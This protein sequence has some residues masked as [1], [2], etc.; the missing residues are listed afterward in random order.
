MGI[1]AATNRAGKRAWHNTVNELKNGK[2]W[3][4]EWGYWDGAALLRN[5]GVLPAPLTR[6][7]SPGV[8][9]KS[10]RRPSRCRRRSFCWSPAGRWRRTSSSRCRL[11]LQEDAAQIPDDNPITA[12]KVALGKKFF[13]DKRWSASGTV[14]CAGCHRP[15]H[16]WSDSRTFSVDFAGQPTPRHAPTIVNR[17]FSDRQ[18][19]SG[20]RAS[21]EDAGRARRQQDGRE[22]RWRTWEPIPAYRQ[23][24]RAVF[25]RELRSRRRGPGHRRRT[26]G[27]SCP[28]SFAL[29]PLPWPATGA[30]CR[31]SAQRGLRLFEGKAMCARVPRRLQLHRRGLPQHR[32]RHGQAEPRPR[33]LHEVTGDDRRPGRVQDADAPRRGPAR[34][35]H[36][37]R[38]RADARRRGRA[39]TIGAA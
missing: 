26:C 17:L 8:D 9:G 33:P 27:R 36:A 25:G 16:G 37:R 30:R 21:L 18:H 7:F 34:S 5:I 12:E 32:R 20:L 19:W 14:S 3:V 2:I 28:A 35:V 10:T 29:R 24:F 39:T 13:W 11:G 23:E 6:P 38:Q 22:G 4:H 1:H 31:T 15:D